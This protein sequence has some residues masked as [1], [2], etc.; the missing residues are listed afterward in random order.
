MADEWPGKCPDCGRFCADIRATATEECLKTVSG[1][2][3]QHGNVD[4]SKQ[5]WAWEDFFGEE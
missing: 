1:V 5:P 4:L 2:C 3:G